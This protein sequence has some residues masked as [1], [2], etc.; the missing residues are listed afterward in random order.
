MF[1]L[2]AIKPKYVEPTKFHV[3][4]AEIGFSTFV[5]AFVFNVEHFALGP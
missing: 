4:T 1:I 3:Y 5:L 2:F